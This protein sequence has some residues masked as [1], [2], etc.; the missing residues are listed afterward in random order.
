[1]V[2]LSVIVTLIIGGQ[3]GRRIFSRAIE[4]DFIVVESD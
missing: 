3:R 2:L 4:S 1:V